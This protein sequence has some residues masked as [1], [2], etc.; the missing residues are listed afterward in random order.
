MSEQIVEGSGRD[1]R[2]EM[3]L[4]TDREDSMDSKI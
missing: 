2:K 4:K 1:R 3:D